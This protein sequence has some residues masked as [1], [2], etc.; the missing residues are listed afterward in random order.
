MCLWARGV[1]G[2]RRLA[3]VS[4]VFGDGGVEVLLVKSGSFFGFE[5]D[6]RGRWAYG[7]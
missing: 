4:V 1:R 2:A 7:A 3:G 6:E 5:E